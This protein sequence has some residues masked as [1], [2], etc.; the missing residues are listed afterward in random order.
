[1]ENMLTYKGHPVMRKDNLI[2][3]GSVENKYIIVITVLES[4]KSGDLDMATKLSI[5][6]QLNDPDISVTDRVQKS[7][8]RNGLYEAMDLAVIW[9]ERTLSG[10]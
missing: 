8:T 2:Y 9:L 7:A 10:K 5:E 3:F 4:A 6:L 1:M